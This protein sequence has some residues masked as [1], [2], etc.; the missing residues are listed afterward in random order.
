MRAWNN[1]AMSRALTRCLL[2]LSAMAWLA[3][4]CLA[5]QAQPAPWYTWESQLDGRIVCAQ[6]MRGAWKRLGGPFED[7]RCEKPLP[8]RTRPPA[9]T[10]R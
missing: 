5:M 6:T 2:R 3:T 4:A 9:S 8:R 10:A 1:A 7:G